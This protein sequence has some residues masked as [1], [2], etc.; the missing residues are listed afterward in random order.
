MATLRMM[1]IGESDTEIDF[2]SLESII[3]LFKDQCGIFAEYIYCFA[4]DTL[5]YFISCFSHFSNLVLGTHA[6]SFV[7]R[8]KKV[9]ECAQKINN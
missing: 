5:S 9:K 3:A 6:L 4:R 7:P 2:S 1:V 8:G